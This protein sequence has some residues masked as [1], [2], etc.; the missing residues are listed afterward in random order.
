[1]HLSEV[2]VF[3]NEFLGVDVKGSDRIE[4]RLNIY[5]KAIK[6]RDAK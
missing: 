3:L 1:M 5:L 6:E 4:S 2:R